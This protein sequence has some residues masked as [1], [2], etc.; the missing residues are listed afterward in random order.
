MLA[1]A[2]RPIGAVLDPER[3]RRAAHDI[4]R[5]A[6]DLDPSDVQELVRRTLTRVPDRLDEAVAEAGDAIAEAG[7]AVREAVQRLPIRRQPRRR[8]PQPV[9]VALVVIGLGAIALAGWLAFRWRSTARAEAGDARLDAEAVSRAAG[10]GMDATETAAIQA[11]VGVMAEP[12]PATA[13]PSVP[14]AAADDLFV[15]PT[16]GSALATND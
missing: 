1:E 13:K 6:Q 4:E 16:V 2:I 12:A 3:V 8:R 7:D 10:E 15:R 11:G 5:A 9:Q 14:A